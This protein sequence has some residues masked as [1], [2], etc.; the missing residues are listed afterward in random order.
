MP[1]AFT[2]T[3][4]ETIRDK[5]MEAGRSCFLRFGMAK[6]TLDDLVKPAGIAKAS[7]YLFFKSKEALFLELV[8]AEIPAMMNRLLDGSFGATNNTREALVLLT[9]GIAHEIQ[10]NEFA[11]IMLDNPS[12]LEQFAAATDLD[13]LLERVGSFYAPMVVKVQEAQER[14]DIIP[15]NPSQI[16]YSLGTIKMLALNKN[17]MPL[18]L[19]NSMMEFVPEVLAN[20]LTCTAQMK[21][22]GEVSNAS[23]VSE[24]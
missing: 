11:R 13:G 18:E 17:K 23:A 9:R 4:K 22:P 7:F 12:E 14:G 1:R 5:L 10:T 3:E 2:A 19:Y 24:E 16:L 20:G 21:S 15:G 6:T 8:V